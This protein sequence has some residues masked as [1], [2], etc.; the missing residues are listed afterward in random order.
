MTEIGI[1]TTNPVDGER[2]N[3]SKWVSVVEVTDQINALP[4][5]Q[6]LVVADSCFSGT[7]AR[8]SLPA[9]DADLAPALKWDALR[10]MARQRA[11]V[12][13]SSGGV[14]PVVDGGAGANSLFSGEKLLTSPNPGVD[15]D[16]AL[17]RRP[18]S[19]NNAL[20]AEGSAAT[21]TVTRTGAA[22]GSYSVNYATANGAA[23]AGSDYTTASGT[24]TF[25][26]GETSKTVSVATLSDAVSE[27]SETFTLNLS[28]PT[29]GATI[30]DGQG[31]GTITNWA[32]ALP[33]QLQA[34]RDSTR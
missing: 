11:R 10:T 23:T 12:V 22:T 3:R 17:V 6:V 32:N 7:M 30:S 26:S 14:E 1:A 4:A 24:L 15:Q 31:A 19:V 18:A 25:A 21:F 28:A 20:A 8:S 33:G 13:L 29:G 27:G 16:E 5:R 9:A 34:L 2:R